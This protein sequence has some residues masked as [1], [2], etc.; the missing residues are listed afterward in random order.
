MYTESPSLNDEY[1]ESDVDASDLHAEGTS[2]YR[3]QRLRRGT[4]LRSSASA[5]FALNRP[6]ITRRTIRVLAP[7]S[8]AVLIGVS[9][10]LAWQSYGGLMIRAW[11]PSLGWLLPPPGP[12]ATSAELQAQLKPLALDLAIVRRTVEHLGSNQDQLARKEDQMRQAF[13]TL[14]AA[15]QDIDQKILALAPPAPR[16]HAPPKPPQPPAQ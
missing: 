16:A 10:T 9:A 14:Q 4:S 3:A 15:E 1:P 2:S 7:P 11:A 6:S 5:R 8:I 13:V 12:A